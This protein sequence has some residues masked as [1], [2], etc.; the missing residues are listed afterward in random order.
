MTIFLVYI[1]FI[2]FVIILL[3][4]GIYLI[5]ALRRRTLSFEKIKQKIFIIKD[6]FNNHMEYS[7]VELIPK[8]EI[9]E[10]KRLVSNKNGLEAFI[11]CYH[12]YVEDM[13]DKMKAQEYASII[14]SYKT[15]LS[16]KIVREKYKISYILYLISEFGISTDEVSHFAL[17]SLNSDSM[18][19]RNNSLRIIRNTGNIE[20]VLKAILI[21]ISQ[22]HYY[23]Y[24][25]LVDFL[26]N[27]SGEK[28][29]LNKALFENFSKFNSRFKRLVLEHFSNGL[30]ADENIKEM[31][32]EVL[33]N[34]SDKNILITATR[35]FGRIIDLRA[36]K[37]IL[38]NLDNPQWEIRAIS[39][40]VISKYNNPD[41][42]SK[43]V[44]GLKDNNYYV[45]YNSA[46]SYIQMEE[47]EN[48]L[49]ELNNMTDVFS[50]DITLYAMYAN[51]IIDYE[52]YTIMTEKVEEELNKQW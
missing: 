42:I 24:R 48:I 23:N 6:I 12:D 11:K 28:E 45:R 21:I 3:V 18:Y 36:K 17:E 4:I 30:N 15:L 35:Y 13:G 5:L 16:N 33:S 43:V 38:Q 2:V 22:N 1:S 25:V 37:I 44:E 20:L 27:F 40:K 49:N 10:L 7:N 39:A 8:S 51:N 41:S 52:A 50:K 32:L 31:V 26:D 34:P 46:F 14:I 47:E 19:V 9:E 29:D